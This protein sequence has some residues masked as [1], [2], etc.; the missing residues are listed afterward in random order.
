MTALPNS[1]HYFPIERGRYDVGPG[2]FRFGTDFGNGQQDQRMF[3]IDSEFDRYRRNKLEARREDLAKYYRIERYARAE[4][5]TVAKFITTRLAKEYPQ[6]FAVTE[7]DKLLELACGLTGE[8]LQFDGDFNLVGTK[9]QA[10]STTPEYVSALDALTCQVQEDLSVVSARTKGEHWISAIHAC[11]PNYWAPS[12]KIGK[13][14]ASVHA[15]VAGMDQ[16]NRAQQAMIDAM[17]F[18][19]PFVRFTWGLTTDKYL[20]HHPVPAPGHDPLLWR[21]RDF[22]PEAPHLFLR[23]ERQVAWGFPE[24]GCALFTIRTYLT[25]CINVRGDTGKR[26]SLISAIEDMSDEQLAYKGLTNRASDILDWL[27]SNN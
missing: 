16:T 3:Q 2:L 22:S 26:N 14:F 21:G 10:S 7:A 1:P 19:G 12:D 11:A 13:S 23:V 6:Y 5:R 8:R 18:K 9:G 25:D 27:E 15:P 24:I 17:I 4:A 20:N